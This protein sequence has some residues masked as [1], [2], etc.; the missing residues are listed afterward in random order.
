MSFTRNLRSTAASLICLT[1]TCSF[2]A[3]GCMS[4]LAPGGNPSGGG[5][6]GGG[7]VLL[8]Q[9]SNCAVE[10]DGFCRVRLAFNPTA[11]NRT[12]SVEVTASLTQSRVSYVVGDVNNNIVSNVPNPLTNVSSSTFMNTSTSQHGIIATELA[13]PNATYRVVI[14]QQ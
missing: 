11:A 7:Q 14:R 13:N 1:L 6:G 4:T 9:T 10:G 2:M 5:G 8:D 3:V 12:I